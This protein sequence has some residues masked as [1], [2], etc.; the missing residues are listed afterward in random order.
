MKGDHKKITNI[1]KKNDHVKYEKEN[2][3]LKLREIATGILPDYFIFGNLFIPAP[4]H[5]PC[6]FLALF[7]VDSNYGTFLNMTF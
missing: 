1:P 2:G 4:P 7:C 5:S 3:D 6:P